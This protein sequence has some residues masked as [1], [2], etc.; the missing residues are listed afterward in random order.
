M[1]EL[2]NILTHLSHLLVSQVAAV[3]HSVQLSDFDF[4]PPYIDL[5]WTPY[6]VGLFLLF[7]LM[8]AC[9]KSTGLRIG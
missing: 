8:N 7:V 1:Q 6:V 3:V 4:L 2:V 9:F 5:P